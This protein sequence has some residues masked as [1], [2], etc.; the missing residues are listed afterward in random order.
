MYYVEMNTVPCIH[1]PLYEPGNTNHVHSNNGS[2]VSIISI[3]TRLN[4]VIPR[5]FGS[6][7]RKGI[8]YK[9]DMLPSER[10]IQWVR[11]IKRPKREAE[12]QQRSSTNGKDIVI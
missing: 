2:C 7:Q 5:K 9:E 8:P 3:V 12:N 4:V 10:T 1:F 11:E 6:I